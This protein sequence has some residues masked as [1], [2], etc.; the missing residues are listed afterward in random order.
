[1]E[2]IQGPVRDDAAGVLL[3]AIGPL[4][5]GKR[6]P[7]IFRVRFAGAQKFLLENK[8]GTGKFGRWNAIG[9]A[10]TFPAAAEAIQK[11]N[12]RELTKHGLSQW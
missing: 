6:K 10:T 11:F 3:Y 12:A 7:P 5:A 4:I 1:M 8:H 2:L 9:E